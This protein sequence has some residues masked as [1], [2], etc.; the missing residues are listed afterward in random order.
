MAGRYPCAADFER[1]VAV[2]PAPDAP[3]ATATALRTAIAG[4]SASKL[5]VMLTVLAAH[6]LAVERRRGGGGWRQKVRLE[7]SRVTALVQAYEARA[8]ADRD[9]LDTMI[10]YAQTARCRWIALLEGL[11]EPPP[12]GRCDHC[13]N[14]LGTAMPA[15]GI[16]RGVTR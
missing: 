3:P 6:G 4:L 10:A 1:L 16:A 7:P 9:R 5:R 12:F 15:V 2:L 13:D 8:K 11:G 14:C